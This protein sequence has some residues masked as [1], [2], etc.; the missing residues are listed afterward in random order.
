MFRGGDNGHSEESGIITGPLQIFRESK[1]S[2]PHCA[3]PTALSHNTC[4]QHPQHEEPQ[5]RT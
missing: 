1:T 4:T 2:Q 3:K 5:G